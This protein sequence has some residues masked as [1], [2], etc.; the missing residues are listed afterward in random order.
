MSESNTGTT[1]LEIYM[2]K[3][4]GFLMEN[5]RRF[6]QLETRNALLESALQEAQKQSEQLQQ[7]IKTGEITIEQS[8][9]GLQ[10]LTAERDSLRV[11]IENLQASANDFI[12]QRDQIQLA[13]NEMTNRNSTNEQEV[14]QLKSRVTTA[15]N[16]YETLK[17]NY[18]LVTAALNDTKADLAKEQERA[19]SYG[20]AVEELKAQLESAQEQLTAHV[21]TIPELKAE[22]E[23]VADVSDSQSWEPVKRK[24]LAKKNN[25]NSEWVDG[26]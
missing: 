2:T 10:A 22:K 11:Q 21:K 23:P 4:E 15:T 25:S 8:I 19:A 16:D 6:L 5:I 18:N 17:S 13:L 20:K 14:Q 26:N 3:Q 12:N 7:Q 1:P 24:K 9:A